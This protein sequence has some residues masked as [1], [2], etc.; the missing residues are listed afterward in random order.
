LFV[1]FHPINAVGDVHFFCQTSKKE[2]KRRRVEGGGWRVE[3]GGREEGGGRREEGGERE[4]NHPNQI[5][6]LLRFFLTLQR[7]LNL[8]G[9]NSLSTTPRRNFRR[10]SR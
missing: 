1:L 2:R 9:A 5:Y 4:T 8:L 7:I 3:G 6:G 10:R